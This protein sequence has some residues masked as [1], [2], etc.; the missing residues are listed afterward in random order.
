[1]QKDPRYYNLFSIVCGAWFLLTGWA[2][3]FLMNL[4]I[5]YP[6]AAAGIFLWYKGRQIDRENKWNRA[7]LYLHVTGLVISA[8][9]LIA[10]LIT[11]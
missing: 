5:S 1:M 9:S 4:V 6:F 11:N 10:L 7:A 8:G 2:W 3:V